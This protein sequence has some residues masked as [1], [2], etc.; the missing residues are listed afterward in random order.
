MTS[1]DFSL[2]NSRITNK[3]FMELLNQYGV[4]HECPNKAITLIESVSMYGSFNKLL[5]ILKKRPNVDSELFSLN[6][7]ARKFS[8]KQLE[9]IYQL[10]PD[11]FF[12]M[13][14]FLEPPSFTVMINNHYSQYTKLRILKLM[15][16]YGIDIHYVCPFNQLGIVD[17]CFARVP[18]EEYMYLAKH[19]INEFNLNVYRKENYLKSRHL[20]PSKYHPD[21]DI[22]YQLSTSDEQFYQMLLNFKKQNKNHVNI[23]DI[24]F[25][26]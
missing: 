15:K 24:V 6:I 16:Q 14:D 21:F 5:L 1:P 18:G 13:N 7:H 4:D 25:E 9:Q 11:S 20:Y 3:R 23:K 22:A 12:K 17:Y 10:L 26:D 2:F 19:L 8:I